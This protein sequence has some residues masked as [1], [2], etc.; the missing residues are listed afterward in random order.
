MMSQCLLLVKESG[1][2]VPPKTY[3]LLFAK[4]CT[5]ELK[6]IV[7]ADLFLSNSLLPRSC[8]AVATSLEVVGL[9]ERRAVARKFFKYEYS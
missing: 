8:M 3:F 9:R 7:V 6:S 1:V 5:Q 2:Q 4:L